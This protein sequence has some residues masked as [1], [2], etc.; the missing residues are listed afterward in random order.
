MAEPQIDNTEEQVLSEEEQISFY[1]I[2]F[3]N[4]GQEVTASSEIPDLKAREVVMV[5][6]D[7]GPEPAIVV[8]RA[9]SCLGCG[10]IR[11]APHALARRASQ[12][13]AGRYATI[14]SGRPPPS[15][16]A[17]FSLSSINSPCA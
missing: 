4:K 16:V 5:K 10:V 1:R 14:D 13:E 3:R 6:T 15:T 11:R 7:H 9:P 2:C 12:E 17:R 8:S